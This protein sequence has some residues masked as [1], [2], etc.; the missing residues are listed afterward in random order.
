[1]DIH[2]N[3]IARQVRDSTASGTRC[4]IPAGSTKRRFEDRDSQCARSLLDGP[5][6]QDDKPFPLSDTHV[7]RQR[8]DPVQP[9]LLGHDLSKPCQRLGGVLDLHF[10]SLL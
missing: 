2:E 10:L 4:V 1:V 9:M 6:G 3:Q 7:P 5:I 8:F